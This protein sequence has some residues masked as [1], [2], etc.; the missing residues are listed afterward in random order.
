[1]CCLR[2]RTSGYFGRGGGGSKHLVL[3][4]G[5]MAAGCRVDGGDGAGQT[6]PL[7][8]QL[9]LLPSG[10]LLENFDNRVLLQEPSMKRAD[11]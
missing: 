6:I 7:L 3:T 11:P 5:L 10:A 4:S 2:F 9:A 8:L 1:M